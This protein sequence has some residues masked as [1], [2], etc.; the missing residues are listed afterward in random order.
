MRKRFLLFFLLLAA[1]RLEA[2]APDCPQTSTEQRRLAE[3]FVRTPAARKAIPEGRIRVLHVYCAERDKESRRS[4]LITVVYNYSAN[5]AVRVAFDAASRE[6]V[7]SDT[8]TGRPQTSAEEREEAFGL[9]REKA[10]GAN[11]VLEGGFVVDPPEG[12]PREGRYVQVQVLSSDR[13]T[14]REFVT[15]DLS[16]G[17][18]VARRRP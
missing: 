8:L 1:V 5:V 9:V 17:A 4:A 13:W 2:Q 10:D 16:R 18:I 6:L 11:F 3:E 14:L 15:V 12:A 7:A